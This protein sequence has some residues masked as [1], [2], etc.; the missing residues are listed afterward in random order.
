MSGTYTL[1]CPSC[2]SA[3]IYYSREQWRCWR[4]KTR[5]PA[6]QVVRDGKRGPLLTRVLMKQRA[7]QEEAR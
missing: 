4:C 5:F 2:N 7:Q 6:D 3:C 1:R